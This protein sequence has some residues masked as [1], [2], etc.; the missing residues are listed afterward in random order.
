MDESTLR[1]KLLQK[2]CHSCKCGNDFC[3]ESDKNGLIMINTKDLF[4]P[5]CR[6]CQR[7]LQMELDGIYP[8]T[9]ADIM[10]YIR[11][12]KWMDSELFLVSIAKNANQLQRSNQH[13]QK[14]DKMERVF[15][16]KF[17]FQSHNHEHRM[18]LRKQKNSGETV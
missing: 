10:Q 15:L 12:Q 9:D 5:L 1:E 16:N 4:E 18:F 13:I 2:G 7:C 3:I 14:L 17:G 11:L 6:A 8:R